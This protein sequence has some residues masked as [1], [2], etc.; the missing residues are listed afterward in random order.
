MNLVIKKNTELHKGYEV[1]SKGGLLIGRI[2]G[3]TVSDNHVP[4]VLLSL[5]PHTIYGLSHPHVISDI[6][7]NGPQNL[8][9][10]KHLGHKLFEHGMKASWGQVKIKNNKFLTCLDTF[11]SVK[12]QLK[13]FSVVSEDDIVNCDIKV[14]NKIVRIYNTKLLIEGVFHES[15]KISDIY[16]RV[17]IN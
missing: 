10:S 14:D 11:Y 2:N 1:L 13:Q 8:V 12:K 7:N 9:T 3:N 5:E 16:D 17:N 4:I 15:L 6:L